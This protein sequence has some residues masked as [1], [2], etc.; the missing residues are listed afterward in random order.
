MG[1]LP[2]GTSPGTSRDP[3][4]KG[5]VLAYREKQ[6]SQHWLLAQLDGQI[7]HVEGSS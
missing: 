5:P 4:D 1:Y 7:R 2:W 3:E 6:L